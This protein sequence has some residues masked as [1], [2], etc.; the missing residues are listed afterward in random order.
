MV[1]DS[2]QFRTLRVAQ[3]ITATNY[4]KPRCMGMYGMSLHHT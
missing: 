1:F 2:P 4:R 3:S